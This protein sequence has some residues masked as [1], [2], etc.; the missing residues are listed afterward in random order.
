MLHGEFVRATDYKCGEN[1]KYLGLLKR[2]VAWIPPSPRS[3]A[4][5]SP[6]QPWAQFTLGLVT[7]PPV[8]TTTD[9]YVDF[10]GTS[11]KHSSCQRI[12]FPASQEWIVDTPHAH[13]NIIAEA[14]VF[15]SQRKMI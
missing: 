14:F 4:V 6:G 3:A 13:A 12:H 2:G 11:G 9:N 1:V 7:G 15:D 5:S 10:P 8:R